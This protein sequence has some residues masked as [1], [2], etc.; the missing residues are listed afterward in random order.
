MPPN[1]EGTDLAGQEHSCNDCVLFSLCF[2]QDINPDERERLNGVIRRR[3]GVHRSAHLHHGGQSARQLA[4]LRSGSIKAYQVSREG[5]ELVT[6]FYLPGDVIGLDA[7]STGEHAGSAVALEECRLCEIPVN[8]F[9]KMLGESPRLNQVMLRLLAEE[10]AEA[11][12]LLLVVG[13]LDAR[14]R[15]ALFLL[16]LSRRLERRGLDPDLFRLSMDRRD[17]ANYLGLTI[18]TVSRTL[19][20]LQRDGVIHVRGK[21]VRIVDR[22]ALS[23]LAHLD[24]SSRP[25]RAAG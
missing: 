20:A 11:R 5:D 18:E 4:V 24:E 14:T 23:E 25:Q 8:D 19:S 10:M 12:R 9:N 6:G 2:A 15:V 13:R 17:I 22:R 21:N 3:Q 16:S 1:S 7:F